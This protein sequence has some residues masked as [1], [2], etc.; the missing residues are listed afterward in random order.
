V[1]T[2]AAQFSAVEVWLAVW[3]PVA[4]TTLNSES[5]VMWP[6]EPPVFPELDC[7]SAVNPDPTA[8]N[9]PAFPSRPMPPMT[10]SSAWVVAPDVVALGVPLL[11]VAVPD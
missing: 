4:V 11:P 1:T 9:S 2:V 7:A 8:V 5:I 3:V 6:A 10:S